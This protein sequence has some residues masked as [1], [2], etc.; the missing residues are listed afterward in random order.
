MIKEK[1]V[2]GIQQF[3][4][5]FIRQLY[6]LKS[7]IRKL[8]MILMLPVATAVIVGV[9]SGDE[10][11]VTYEDT[12]STLFAYVCV[13]IW[14]G[15]F[16]SI[17]KREYMSNLSLMA[18]ISSKFTVQAFICLFQSLI[19]MLVS[20]FFVEFPKEGIITYSFEAETF[21]TI[22]LI[23]IASDAL[24]L[25]ISSI[26]RSGDIANIIAPIVLIIQLVMSGV[27]FEL[28][29]AAE[30]LSN[31]TFSK[32]GMEGLGAIAGM[33]DLEY[34]QIVHA[35]DEITRKTLTDVIERKVNDGFASTSENLIKI[36][37]VLLGFSIALILLSSLILRLVSK[38]SR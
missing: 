34:Y 17:L 31:I 11:F 38:D 4:I 1:R 15:L 36:W 10:V 37:L 12:K 8:L 27:L 18:Y 28:N 29:G 19:L 23:M 14:I 16:N 33:N 20:S 3:G 9:V 32:W 35:K 5:L 26:V 7:N 30:A 6:M 25:F 22:F 13:A 21:I 2:S 24:G